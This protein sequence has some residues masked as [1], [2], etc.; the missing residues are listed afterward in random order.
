VVPSNVI[1]SAGDSI[2]PSGFVT[3]A[4]TAFDAR[5]S[6]R[7]DSRAIH[8]NLEPG[9]PAF[10]RPLDDPTVHQVHLLAAATSAP[11]SVKRPLELARLR[12]RYREG[13]TLEFPIRLG[14][15]VE[16]IWSQDTP[17]PSQPQVAWRGLDT[18]AE[19]SGRWVQLYHATFVN[20]TPDRPVEAIE[21]VSSMN[22]PS[23]VVSGITIE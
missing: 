14:I 19:M 1:D 3:H 2:I 9:L 10:T 23:L 15:E 17:A 4:G 16:D 20:P 8:I 5:W 18:S 7:I 22:L 13:P 12:I 6:L 11:S 21:I